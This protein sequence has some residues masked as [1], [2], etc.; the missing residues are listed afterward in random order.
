MN[1]KRNTMKKL[2]LICMLAIAALTSCV[3]PVKFQQNAGFIDY[4]AFPGMFLSESNSVSFDYQPIGSLYA[5]E[6][7]GEF[8]VVKKKIGNNEIYGDEF[9]VVDGKYRQ[10]S[11]QSALAFAAAKAK[12]M[13]GDGVINLH[14]EKID[15]GYAVTGMVIRRK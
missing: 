3:T 11:P 2:L 12:E 6:M 14:I 1:T 9:A 8:Q 10:A 7:S 15:G 13:G 4:A 5:E